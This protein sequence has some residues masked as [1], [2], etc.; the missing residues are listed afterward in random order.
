MNAAL[1]KC[2][3][4]LGLVVAMFGGSVQAAEQSDASGAVFNERPQV[5]DI[6]LSVEVST[7]YANA[8]GEALIR[9][10]HDRHQQYPY[11]YEEQ[12]MVLIDRQGNRETR[13]LRRY[14]RVDEVF[15]ADKGAV[16]VARYMLVFDSPNDVKGVVL[17]AEKRGEQTHQSM[18][19]PAFGKVMI[20]NEG[21]SRLEKFLGSDFSIENLIGEDVDDYDYR[22]QRDVIV[23]G[24]AYFIIDVYSKIDT[25]LLLRR[26]F[27][28]QDNIYGSRTDHYDDLGR[29]QKRQSNHDLTQVIG[30][31][32]RA[33]MIL[34]DDKQTGH[35]SLLKINRRVFSADY[36]PLEYFTPQWLYQNSMDE[37]Q[38][39]P[40]IKFPVEPAQK[41]SQETSKQTPQEINLNEVVDQ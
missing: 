17:L 14:S 16:K 26:H 25:G 11:V 23:D 18:Y 20:T 38:Y 2:A 21:N 33:N 34:M 28:R 4:V 29:L 6:E 12:S 13:N 10:M 40:A 41:T 8:S 24:M 9:L 35:Q 5:T 36:V 3:I 39:E 19:L 27:I 32:W 15:D 30:S 31:V 7:Q 37:L 22:R 1:P